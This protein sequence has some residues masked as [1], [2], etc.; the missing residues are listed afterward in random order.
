MVIAAGKPVS[1]QDG[2]ALVYSNWESEASRSKRGSEKP[3]GCPVMTGHEGKWNFVDCKTAYSRVVCKTEASEYRGSGFSC[4]CCGLCSCW[5]RG[6]R[7]V[8]MRGHY[9]W[10]ELSCGWAFS[11]SKP[12]TGVSLRGR[13]D[14]SGTGGLHPG[15]HRCP[16]HRWLCDL[17]KEEGL[18]LLHHPLREDTGRHGHHQH[19]YGHGAFLNHLSQGVLVWACRVSV[20]LSLFYFFNYLFLSSLL[21]YICGM[22]GL[23]LFF[24][25]V[26][27]FKTLSFITWV[28]SF[29]CYKIEN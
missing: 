3:V 7:N 6:L 9:H 26:C 5:S 23:C 20:P 24:F 10:A 25:S 4:L 18:L 19:G 27:C 8:V 2:S 1:W 28:Q 22:L 29:Q 21:I 11:F 15:A 16:F 13:G 14:L 12:L 17:Q